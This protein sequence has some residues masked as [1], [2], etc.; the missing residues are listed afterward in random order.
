MTMDE[1]G[2]HHLADNHVADD[3]VADN[4][5]ADDHFADNQL[6]DSTQ[7]FAAISAPIAEPSSTA[8]LVNCPE[9]GTAAMIEPTRRDAQDFCSRCDFPLFW[10]KSQLVLMDA[11]DT[12][13]ASTRRLPGTVGRAAAASVPCPHCTEP[14]LPV[15]VVCIRCGEPM[16]IVAPPP[17]PP[18]APLPEP[19]LVPEAI[20][21]PERERIWMWVVLAIATALL[22]GITAAVV[23]RHYFG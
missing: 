23:L 2:R 22:V 6:G 17:P 20:V 21:E 12:G 16:Q 18:P 9:C 10:R 14:N 15:A 5:F 4:H 13:G 11:Q 8:I 19:V 3:H 1:L 7:V